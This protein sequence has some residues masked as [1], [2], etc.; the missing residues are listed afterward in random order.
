VVHQ[1]KVKIHCSQIHEGAKKGDQ[2]VMMELPTPL[3]LC[4]D[5]MIE[6]FNKPKMMKKEKM[7]HMWFNTFFVFDKEEMV[8]VNGSTESTSS[9]NT[10]DSRHAHTTSNSSSHTAQESSSFSESFFG[11][12]G[13]Q[14]SSSSPW[15]ISRQPSH[16]QQQPHQH[17]QQPSLSSSYPL[18]QSEM[19]A[20]KTPKNTRTKTYLTFTSTKLE[21]DKANKDK[22]QKVFSDNFKVKFYFTEVDKKQRNST[23]S[24]SSLTVDGTGDGV[25]DH[26]ANA[27]SEDLSDTDSE[28]E[29]API[30]GETS[31]VTHV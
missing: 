6:F 8:L 21:L 14:L 7:F 13:N 1:L 20:H 17:H 23:A 30:Q 12:R 11:T 9:N 15:S 27:D 22:T 2:Y 25:S 5:I 24:D 19:S 18:Q 4:G 26:E 29:W 31:Q 10:N 28:D 3:P 16:P